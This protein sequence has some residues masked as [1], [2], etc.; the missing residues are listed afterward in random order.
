[1]T[2]NL[3]GY[4]GN[5]YEDGSPI[6]A[7]AV[8]VNSDTLAEK[9]YNY[10][11]E[12]AF[13]IGIAVGD[14]L[15]I[16]NRTLSSASVRSL[17]SSSSFFTMKKIG[18]TPYQIVIS[19]D[20]SYMRASYSYF[21][22]AAS[23]TTLAFIIAL[24][25]F[26]NSIRKQFLLPMTS[27]IRYVENLDMDTSHNAL[28]RLDNPAFLSLIEKINE[29]LVRLETKT[30]T[31]RQSEIQIK[32]A[33]IQRHKAVIYSLKKQ[34]NAHFTVNTINIIKI[35]ISKKELDYARELCDGLSTL[36]RYAHDEDEF[37]NAWDEFLVLQNYINIMNIRY[38]NKFHAE[39]EIDDR[40]M[41]Y[42]IPRMLLQPIIENALIHGYRDDRQDCKLEIIGELLED[43]L[44]ITVKDYGVGI[45][46]AQLEALRAKLS[47]NNT[48]PEGI[49]HIA[50]LNINCRIKSY[51]GDAFGVEVN[52]A[53]GCGTAVSIL[54]GASKAM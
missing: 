14:K 24:L 22:I 51:Y 31:I 29:M 3:I 28:P 39:F 33:E 54:L 13:C 38:K 20:R 9:L 44:K 17:T 27:L 26:G 45:P 16:S 36:I 52:S 23:V 19:V 47:L 43:N 46:P 21:L 25:Y 30:Q 48:I 50:L 41:D 11:S 7:V 2:E 40:F 35:L 42:R 15:L 8:L 53:P 10:D 5:L 6:G 34:I 18:V 1:D 4:G 12:H 49:D 37:I 32:N